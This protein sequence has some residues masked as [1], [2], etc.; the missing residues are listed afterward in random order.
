MDIETIREYCLK[1]KKVEEGFPFG[2]TVLVFKVMGKMFLLAR[3][4]TPVLEFNVKCD[5][6]KAIEWREQYQA[7]QPGYHMNKKMWNTVIMDNSIPSRTI[8]EMIDDSYELV[9]RSLP[10]KAQKGLL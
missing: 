4:D 6:E 2:D 1:K 10:K 9:V 5:P 8:R 3:L 7:V